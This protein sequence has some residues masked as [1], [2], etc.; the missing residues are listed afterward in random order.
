[1]NIQNKYYR[2]PLILVVDD[3]ARNIQV[4]GNLLV[5]Q[6]YEISVAIN[7]E[8]AIETAK[9]TKPD[10]VLMDIMMPGI[11]GYDT[12][13][14]FKKDDELSNIPIIFLTAKSDIEDV[15]KGFALGGVDYIFKPFNK[16]EVI[17]RIENHLEL[18][19]SKEII[20]EN[21]KRVSELKEKMDKELSIASDYFKSLL[22]NFIDNEYLKVDWKYVPT[23]QLGGDVFGFYFL[24]DHF[25]FYLFDVCGHGVASALYSISVLSNLKNR[26]LPDTD[27]TNPVSVFNSLNKYYQ[28]NE[29]H[30]FY[31]TIWYGSYNV[32]TRELRYAAAGHHP[33]ILFDD[34]DNSELINSPNF[35]VGGKKD[36]SFIDNTIKLSPNSDLYIFSDGTFEFKL[37]NGDNWTIN[38][39]SKFLL[40]RKNIE[41]VELNEVYKFAISN[42]PEQIQKDDFSILKLHFY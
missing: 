18:K 9:L 29:H 40:A 6:G 3:V 20:I 5:E 7:G 8:Q 31:F 36:Y 38:D 10:L 15:V 37:S 30:G 19:F 25:V 4:I 21:N 17:A 32:K 42:N 23:L 11:D 28:M 26:Y 27:F 41:A 35:I 24:N 14:Q 16:S 1:M 22:P 2:K 12:C 13:I 39:L 34:N 33:A